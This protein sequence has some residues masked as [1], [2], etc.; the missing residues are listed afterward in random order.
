[1]LLP[2]SLLLLFIDIII[3]TIII[4]FIM[5]IIIIIELTLSEAMLEIFSRNQ[6]TTSSLR[7]RE[8]FLIF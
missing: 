3:I 2:L 5:M 4:I 8:P 7:F 6:A 1:M